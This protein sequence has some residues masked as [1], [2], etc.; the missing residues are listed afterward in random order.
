L[1]NIREY[2]ENHTT[3]KL[4]DNEALNKDFDQILQDSADFTKTYI[5]SKEIVPPI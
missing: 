1:R 2:L 4:S 5:K 3:T